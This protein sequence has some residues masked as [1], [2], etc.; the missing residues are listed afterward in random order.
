MAGR[1]LGTEGVFTSAASNPSAC[2]LD[3]SMQFNDNALV[4]DERKG[5]AAGSTVGIFGICAFFRFFTSIFD[6]ISGILAGFIQ[7]FSGVFRRPV[8]RLT[9]NE[10]QSGHEPNY[11]RIT[12]RHTYLPDISR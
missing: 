5:I 12:K 9:T 3:A 2:Q 6:G 4:R 11:D 10:T 1:R 8:V 7:R